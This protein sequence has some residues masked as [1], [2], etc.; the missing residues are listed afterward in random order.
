[1]I[2]HVLNISPRTV[3]IHRANVMDKL[4]CRNLAD[5]VRIALAADGSS[6]A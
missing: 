5:A 4:R 1:V 6:E 2:A 3:E